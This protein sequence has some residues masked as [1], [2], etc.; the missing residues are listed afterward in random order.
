[1]DLTKHLNNSL[2]GNFV[3][4][5]TISSSM[6]LYTNI[7]SCD[8]LPE[9][10]KQEQT[11]N[12][13]IPKNN[14][15][16]LIEE[17]SKNRDLQIR[18]RNE[19]GLE[20]CIGVNYVSWT[21]G[22]Y[23]ST[24][25]WKR[26]TYYDSQGIVKADITN[27]KPFR[28]KGSL[29]LSLDINGKSDTHRQ[30]EVFVDLRYIPDYDAIEPVEITRDEN[31]KPIGVD[32]SG[33][34]LGALVF[35][36]RGTSGSTYAPSGIQLFLKSVDLKNGKEEWN[37]YYGNWHNIWQVKRD[38]TSDRQLGNVI[39][40]EWSLVSI[41]VPE[42]IIRD[43]LERPRHGYADL[44]FNPKKVALIGIKYGLNDNYKEDVS[45]KIFADEFGW[46]NII[47]EG[48][49]DFKFYKISHPYDV[50][51]WN[52]FRSTLVPPLS[53][54]EGWIFTESSI[55]KAIG[56]NV[57]FTFENI[58]DPVISLKSSGYNIAA[59]VQTEY[60]K[61]STSITI[62]PH[63][64]KSHTDE[65]LED[66]VQETNSNGLRVMFKPHVDVADDSWRGEI[67][68]QDKAKWFKSYT[69]F[70]V[71]YAKIAE[72]HNVEMFSIG[73]EFK[74]LNGVENRF[75]WENTIKKIREVYSGNLTY[76]ANW[77]D[78]RNV[79]FW[80]LVDVVGIDAYFPISSERNPSLN[81][82]VN[83]WSKWVR[84]LSEWQKEIR[85]DIVFTEIGYRST[86]YAAREPWEYQQ[87]RPI[88]QELQ[89]NCYKAVMESF[90]DKPWFKGAFFWSWTPQKDYGGKFNTDF[91]PQ[92]KLAEK[93]FN[94]E[95]KR[96]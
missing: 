30:G 69:D 79:C 57:F 56:N 62:E 10:S 65:E 18:R 43:P 31:G 88:N 84:E 72:E 53:F 71:H 35:C 26:Q 47:Q 5:L 39:E 83:G 63:P 21:T 40:G 19:Q 42:E 14:F 85:K 58:D 89:A 44:H 27:N 70:I 52:Y 48:D 12:F 82:L 23:P 77:D 68:P 61:T 2:L 49:A 93:V 50:K 78:Y 20:F 74:S 34:T 11:Q 54:E 24:T 1:M 8:K 22:D 28:G 15:E 80:D 94:H 17:K 25:A 7:I 92:H 95:E 29:E 60:M 46:K 51:I 32:L 45:G 3:R 55:F 90:K 33:K 4:V 16:E 76:A 81:E 91:T 86:D 87:D 73:T 67:N 59:I 66:L 38:G 9:P 96:K 64:R 75:E 13:R 37:S 41:E 36:E 6:F